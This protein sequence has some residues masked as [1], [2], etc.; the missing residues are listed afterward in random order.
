MLLPPF[1][2]AAKMARLTTPAVTIRAMDEIF[3][4]TGV[5]RLGRFGDAECRLCDAV[6]T[7]EVVMAYLKH[8]PE[9]FS[10]DAPAGRI[11]L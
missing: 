8:N 3:R 6:R 10:D 2:F 5:M 1:C 11:A 4:E 7:A 9:L